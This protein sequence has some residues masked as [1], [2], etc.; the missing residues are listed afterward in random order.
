MVHT[1]IFVF[2]QLVDNRFGQCQELGTDWVSQ[3]NIVSNTILIQF[4]TI[5]YINIVF[6][7]VHE[8]GT[9]ENLENSLIEKNDSES[10]FQSS[11]FLLAKTK[12]K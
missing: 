7:L 9:T 10:E 4:C 5:Y 2:D 6:N 12:V 8:C 3:Q 11:S 1:H